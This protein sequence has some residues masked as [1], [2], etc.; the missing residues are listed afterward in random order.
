MACYDCEDC[1]HSKE[2][3]GKCTRFEYNCPFDFYS[4]F[5]KDADS[6]HQIESLIA[7]II[8]ANDK[9]QSIV[10]KSHCYG[11]RALDALDFAVRG[12]SDGINSDLSDEWET[13]ISIGDVEN[14]NKRTD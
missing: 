11:V 5:S 2:Y 13:I 7:D 10:D 6:R 9:I 12:I 3:G 4:T 14:E 1:S 8:K